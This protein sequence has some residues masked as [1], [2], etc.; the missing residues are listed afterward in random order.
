MQCALF[1]SGCGKETPNNNGSSLDFPPTVNNDRNDTD[2][3]GTDADTESNADFDARNV[4]SVIR[5]DSNT[6]QAVNVAPSP[7]KVEREVS[8]QLRADKK[9]YHSNDPIEFRATVTST[10]AL[11]S[12]TVTVSGVEGRWA[13][14]YVDDTKIVNV[15]SNEP[16]TV[17]FNSTL[18]SCSV[19]SGI[20]PGEYTITATVLFDDV[21]LTTGTTTITIEE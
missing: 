19:C 18:P 2:R 5:D 13:D 4:N 6:D 16:K 8:I 9:A 11:S 7:K 14:R 21:T 17:T 15:P 3:S 10:T 20:D 1:C 12:A